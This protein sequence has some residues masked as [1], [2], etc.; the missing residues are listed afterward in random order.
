[1]PEKYPSHAINLLQTSS[2]QKQVY[3]ERYVGGSK[4]TEKISENY[5]F[6]GA[7]VSINFISPIIRKASF[8]KAGSAAASSEK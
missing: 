5:F 8:A 3:F 6:V 1:M 7:P 4:A 2:K